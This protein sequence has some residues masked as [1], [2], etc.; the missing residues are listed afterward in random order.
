MVSKEIRSFRDLEVW[1]TAMEL[2]TVSYRLAMI[3]P[4]SERF[5]LSAQL[6]RSSVS[7]PSNI[8]EGHAR[9]GRAY[10]HHVLIA[11]GSTA[12]LETQL[13]A[14]VRL[15][16]LTPTDVKHAV[17]PISQ[18]GQM[19]HALERALGRRLFANVGSVSVLGCALATSGLLGFV[20]RL[21]F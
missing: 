6:R 5:E 1:N 15:Q 16:F 2:V 4:D 11:L 8:A 21:F 20:G 12:E 19:L 14:A 10:R 7:I 13:E 9:R 3:L 17:D 18:V